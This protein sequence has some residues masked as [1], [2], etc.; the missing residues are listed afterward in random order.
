M[1]GIICFIGSIKY[2][3]DTLLEGLIQLQNRGYDSAGIIV[4]KNNKFSIK[5][6]LLLKK[7]LP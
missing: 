5:N 1:C 3:F 7:K 2:C 4:I 6:M